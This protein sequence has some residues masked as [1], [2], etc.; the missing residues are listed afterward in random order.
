M[1]KRNR[2][3]STAAA[4]ALAEALITH[5]ARIEDAGVKL[6]AP[7][8]EIE[9]DLWIDRIKRP[10]KQLASEGSPEQG[11]KATGSS[12]VPAAEVALATA[13]LELAGLGSSLAEDENE[14]K[15]KKGKDKKKKAEAD[16]A[17]AAAGA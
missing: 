12:Q 17:V 11:K 4:D 2:H 15:R 16:V 6:F 9:G 13:L 7:L 1:S 14:K 10:L 3:V 5:R 8:V